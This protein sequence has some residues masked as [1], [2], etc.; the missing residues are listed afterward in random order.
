MKRELPQ[1]K[2]N[3]EALLQPHVQDALFE[4]A[5]NYVKGKHQEV[6]LQT[7]LMELYNENLD[8]DY[9]ICVCLACISLIEMGS[10][11]FEK[12]EEGLTQKMKKSVMTRAAEKL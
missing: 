11:D 1:H 4:K 8:K 10:E 7:C 5:F 3:M 6:N 2:I 9:V 12:I